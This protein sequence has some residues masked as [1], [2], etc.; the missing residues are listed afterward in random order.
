MRFFKFSV[1][2]ILI[3]S[4]VY[5]LAYSR[6]APE[7]MVHIPWQFHTYEEPDFRAD[8]TGFFNPQWVNLVDGLNDGWARI[9]T[10]RGDYWVFLRRNFIYID[11]RMGIYTNRDDIL[12]VNIINPQVVE[13]I[14]RDGRWILINTWLGEKWLNLD[15]EPPMQVIQDFMRP[16]GNTVAVFYQNLETGFTFVHQGDR[17]YF[18]ASA[19]KMPFAFYIFTRAEERL[20]DMTTLISYT[21]GDHWEGSGIIRHNYRLGASFT[22]LRLLEL[23]ITPS[24]N[25]ATRM[26]RRHHNLESYR[27]FIADLGANP[28]HVQ[29]ITYS[30]LTAN[31]AGIFAREIFHYLESGGRYSHYFKR[32]LMNNQYPFII[33]DHPLAS[34]SGWAANFGGAWHDIA[35]V[36]APSPYVLALLSQRDGNAADR[37][38]Y[39]QISMF[40]QNF[41]DTWFPGA[42]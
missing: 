12:P 18:G 40:F 33:S 31:D 10:Y 3:F 39:N 20:T 13:I 15:F 16:F 38:V 34:K 7:G 6:P 11:R 17:V 32:F 25:I 30:Y 21:S 2:I 41:N 1:F 36:Y 42:E 5:I 29:T 9:Q 27:R 26:L 28:N 24:D 8:T 35:I 19:T 23:M 22:Q 4:S 37:R 14:E